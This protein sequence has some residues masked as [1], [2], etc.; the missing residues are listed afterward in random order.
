MHVPCNI[1]FVKNRPQV[2]R[3]SNQFFVNIHLCLSFSAIF[4]VFV[5]LLSD[6]LMALIIFSSVDLEKHDDR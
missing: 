4:V 1:E 3:L 5:C 6:M 2:C